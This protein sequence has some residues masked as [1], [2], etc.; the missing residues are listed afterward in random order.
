M[1]SRVWVVFLD[2]DDLRCFGRIIILIDL[3]LIVEF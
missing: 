3:R 1:I 2:V